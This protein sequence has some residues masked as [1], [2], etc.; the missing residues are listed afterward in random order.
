MHQ[1]RQELLALARK[2]GGTSDR[3][4]LARALAKAH[5]I[6]AAEPVPGDTL[7]P[8]DAMDGDG[9]A[10]ESQP[11][12]EVSLNDE[13]PA[14]PPADLVASDT[15]DTDPPVTD[16]PSTGDPSSIGVPEIHVAVT[17]DEAAPA[18]AEPLPANEPLSVVRPDQGVAHAQLDDLLPVRADPS[19]PAGLPDIETPEKDQGFDLPASF[20]DVGLRDIETGEAGPLAVL[21]HSAEDP[22]SVSDPPSL[23]QQPDADEKAADYEATVGFTAATRE[24]DMSDFSIAQPTGNVEVE[25]RF[26][27]TDPGSGAFRPAPTI[28]PTS[29]S[30]LASE[31]A[32]HPDAAR[33]P[34]A[35]P[36][37]MPKLAAGNPAVP[38]DDDFLPR[39]VPDSVV[40]EPSL[41]MGGAHVTL[42]QEPGFANDD[43]DDAPAPQVELPPRDNTPQRMATGAVLLLLLVFSGWL[44]SMAC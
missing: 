10:A 24:E 16:P 23:P 9:P 42:R 19:G 22:K 11:T 29:D 13:H 20:S 34:E 17:V 28:A 5:L 6:G 18:P 38:V 14:A 31:E 12:P 35:A 4:D 3:R 33:A 32:P 41:G 39:A 1:V 8:P 37:A 43:D 36:P 30:D 25:V 44:L 27:P 2:A 7:M 40:D 15:T 21:P 26:E